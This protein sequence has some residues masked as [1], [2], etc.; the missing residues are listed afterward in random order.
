MNAITTA[1]VFFYLVSQV[2]ATPGI[3]LD[4]SV[5][6]SVVGTKRSTMATTS[7]DTPLQELKIIEALTDSQHSKRA[8]ELATSNHR[9]PPETVSKRDI[10]FIGCSV[11]QQNQI[12]SAISAA[13]GM[14]DEAIFYLASLT[15]ETADHSRYVRW[16]GKF[17]KS[18]YKKVES[19]F[20]SMK[21]KVDSIPYDCSFCSTS[22]SAGYSLTYAYL[23]DV[24]V[25]TM[26][27]VCPN[28]WDASM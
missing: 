14:I 8:G 27:R 4:F 10:S 13:Q 2:S 26:I 25:P 19:R 18:R 1:L 3:I 7:R 17:K 12:N 15:T 5:P 6:P 11:D 20:Q 21:Q 28:F 16:F 23:L 9:I 22:R 24:K